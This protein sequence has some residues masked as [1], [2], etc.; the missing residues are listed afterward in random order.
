MATAC[1]FALD[2]TGTDVHAENASL[3]AQGPVVPVE[4]PG[5]VHAWTV[6]DHAVARQMLNDSRFVK[7]PQAWPAFANGEIPPSWPLISWVVMDNMTTHDGADHSRLRRLVSQAFTPR[8]VEACRPMI[9]K[10]TTELLDRLAATP[11]GEV[12]DLKGKFAY[13]L[14]AAVICDMFGVPA[15]RRAEV[16]K[17]GEVTT[18]TALTEEEAAANVAHWHQ[19]LGDLVDA[20]RREPGEDLTSVLIDAAD[21]E[22]RLSHEELVGTLFLML[23]AGS[24]T[25]MNLLCHAV[26]NLKANPDQLELAMSGKV[27]W[28][29]VAEEVMRVQSPINQLPFR[30]AVEDVE[31]GGVRIPAGQPI[32]MGFGATGRDPKLHGADADRFDI[33]RPN[34]THL[35][36][37]HGA[38]Y[39]MGAPLARM[40]AAIALPALFSRFPDLEIAV[41]D[42]ALDPM[43]S[44]IMN[45]P[46]TLP[47]RLG[48]EVVPA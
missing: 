16:L 25:V 14:P 12:V 28:E 24:E 40:E 21:G 20:K 19:A 32:L 45:G 34:K 26:K 46:L 47:V 9:E 1:P 30:F 38:H 41:P 2:R 31:L 6:V 48:H 13:A 29:E 22:E 15:E 35:S 18:S 8:R 37:G 10:I 5:G 27:A 42:E 36:L 23:G 7:N 11:E 33:T 17:G 39:C 4:L 3:R 44:F 43:P